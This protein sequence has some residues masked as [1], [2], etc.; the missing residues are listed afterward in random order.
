MMIPLETLLD[1]VGTLQMG[2]ASLARILG[3]ADT[4]TERSP[5]DRDVIPSAELSAR[6]VQF[7]Y[8]NGPDVLHGIDL[9]VRPGERV[10]I[11]GRTGS[12]K[13]TLARLLSGVYRPR[14]GS[15][16]ISGIPLDQI[17]PHELRKHVVL[18]T[19]EQY[20]FGGSLRENLELSASRSGRGAQTEA[21]DR[22]LW[23]ALETVGASDWVA[24]LPEKLDTPV[25]AS[26]EH[27]TDAQAQQ[28]ALARL[29]LADPPV[30]ILDEATSQMDPGSARHLERALATVLED[31]TV[32]AIA[33]RL[34]TAHDADRIV[35]M[36]DGRI[37]E[38]GS[39]L[40]LLDRNGAY[41]R[42]WSS[43][44]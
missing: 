39:H 28:L 34:H 22:E 12:G 2:R 30:L 31:R 32:I 4:E 44:L 1:W 27:L 29:L 33:H 5:Q 40:N 43:W 21:H 24:G 19:Q 14:A 42:L 3:V 38:A 26:G 15:V 16:D 18:V 10:A 35:V 37:V 13:S 20:I 11:V 23:S 7:A 41:A 36:E 6:T 17:S 8:E 9:T 25:G